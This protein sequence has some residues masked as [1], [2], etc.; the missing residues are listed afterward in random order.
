MARSA[1]QK[2]ETVLAWWGRDALLPGPAGKR[3]QLER[4]L[5]LHRAINSFA[6]LLRKTF[7]LAVETVDS[8]LK[9]TYRDG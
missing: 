1:W 4:N 3:K 5:A 8:V 2:F 7:R 6:C 9:R